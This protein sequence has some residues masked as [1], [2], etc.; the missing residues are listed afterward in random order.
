MGLGSA[1]NLNV[2]CLSEQA[3]MQHAT[4]PCPRR[5][6]AR[7]SRSRVRFMAE[8]PEVEPR[9]GRRACSSTEHHAHQPARRT[10]ATTGTTLPPMR[11]GCSPTRPTRGRAGQTLRLIERAM[12]RTLSR[13][14]RRGEKRQHSSKSNHVTHVKSSP[15][16]RPWQ[17]HGGSSVT[18]VRRSCLGV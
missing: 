7:S 11:E 8:V 13:L 4:R 10:R 3:N 5:H 9:R 1:L 17:Y 12:T 6:H 16:M 2:H 15:F 14:G 18:H